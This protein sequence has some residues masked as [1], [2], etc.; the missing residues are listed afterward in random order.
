MIYNN[1]N[2]YFKMV[3]ILVRKF[4]IFSNRFPII[5]VI[6]HKIYSLGLKVFVTFCS[7]FP[8]IHSAY[9][10]SKLWIPGVSDIDLI[11]VLRQDLDGNS[12]FNFLKRFSREFNSLRRVF[13]MLEPEILVYDNASFDLTL[14]LSRKYYNSCYRHIF[15]D[16]S[17]LEIPHSTELVLD[18]DI[19]LFN[20]VLA[21]SKT[22][23]SKYSNYVNDSTHTLNY[24]R[25]LNKLSNQLK[26]HKI[27]NK[28]CSRITPDKYYELFSELLFMLNGLCAN[29]LDNNIQNKSALEVSN[30][31][32]KINAAISHEYEFISILLNYSDCCESCFLEGEYSQKIFIVLREN[33]S[34]DR[35]VL[36]L[37]TLLENLSSGCFQPVILT[38]KVFEYLVAKCSP[39]LYYRLSKFRRLLF[40]KDIFAG[41]EYP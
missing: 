31:S 34:R 9:V 39:V 40:G 8:E 36:F 3:K 17:L 27:V 16:K 11:V 22:F 20:T 6:Y 19:D 33:I 35:V 4:V 23:M 5:R 1:K 13:P 30:N 32:N 21:F 41:N 12:E 26:Q 7:R 2:T 24:Y 29:Y 10:K 14:R 37:R 15:G 18:N 25:Y 28:Y 38:S